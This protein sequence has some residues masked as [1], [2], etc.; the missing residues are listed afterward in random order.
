[1]KRREFLAASA[2]AVAG[3]VASTRAW[4]ARA[5]DAP[6]SGRQYFELRRYHFADETKQKAY[7]QFLA[8][9]A[10]PAYN[11]AGVRP[12]GVWKITAADNPALKLEKDGTD[13]YVFLPHNS[14]ES[15]AA[16]EAKLAA[17]EKF[18]ADGKAVLTSPRGQAFSRYES[19]LLLAMEGA[20]HVEETT[21]SPT[22]VFELRTY[23]S[24]N[25]ERAANKL[26]MFNKGEFAVFKQAGM[27]GVFFGGAI[28]GENLPQLTY[29]VAHEKIEDAKANWGK[30]GKVPEWVTLSR[31]PQY[32]GNVS[33]IHDEFVRPSAASQI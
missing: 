7:E 29:M 14:L 28:V 17:D 32:R 10:V 19:T 1:M 12:V 24:P 26:L 16:L 31:D 20:P 22:R 15:V 5:A 6:A 21:K 8:D 9:A 13:L 23:E 2:A 27:P 11:R 3:L 25:P 18:Q 30:F 33:K 4:F